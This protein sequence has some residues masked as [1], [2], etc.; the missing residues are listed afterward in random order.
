MKE[1][2]LLSRYLPSNSITP[3]IDLIVKNNVHL[4]IAKKR[5][6][7]FG[8][9]RPPNSQNPIHRIS[10]NHN[11]NPYAFL[12]TLIHEIAHLMVW[13]KY[14][15]NVTPHGKEWKM[16]YRE[17]MEPFLKNNIFPNELEKVLTKSII[18]S[19]ASSSSD[20]TLSRVL[21]KYNSHQNDILLEDIP[22]NTSFQ[23]ENGSIFLKGVKRRTRYICKN[24]LNNRQYLFHPLTPVWKV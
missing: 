7:K 19:K 3:I 11:L 22:E 8:D 17:L 13:Q 18:N 10:I 16:E 2:D 5:R 23:I 12:I 4:K 6:T 9:Y 15:N 1:K 14:S 20:L 21:R 24:T